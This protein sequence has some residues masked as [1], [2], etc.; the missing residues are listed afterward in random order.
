MGKWPWREICVGAGLSANAFVERLLPGRLG[1][2]V[3]A[4]VE[5]CTVSK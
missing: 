2:L 1:G 3:G 4:V 5:P